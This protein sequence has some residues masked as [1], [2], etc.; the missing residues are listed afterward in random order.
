MVTI[1]HD[2]D[3]FLAL[4]SEFLMEHEVENAM[5]ISAPQI[6]RTVAP[7]YPWLAV[8]FDGSQ[9]TGVAIR[10]SVTH[11]LLFSVVSEPGLR[12]LVRAAEKAGL[13]GNGFVSSL[14][15]FELLMSEF[16]LPLAVRQRLGLYQLSAVKHPIGVPGAA[17]LAMDADLELLTD[18]IIAFGIEVDGSASERAGIRTWIESR[19]SAQGLLIWED[20]GEVVSVANITGKTPNTMRINAVYTPPERRGRGYASACVAMA[21]QRVLDSGHRY[22]TLFTDLS[23][24]TSNHIYQSIGYEWVGEFVQ[25][26]P[27]LT[28]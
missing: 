9:V 20:S 7:P 10:T 5:L 1:S 21:S 22:A 24:P 25:T 2:V 14:A 28:P 18:W 19:F 6:Y 23:N 3:A 16:S 26:A 4:A 12:E 27:K 8:S 13:A 11:R 15:Q 17:R